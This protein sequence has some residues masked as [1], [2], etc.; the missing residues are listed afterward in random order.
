MLEHAAVAK[1]TEVHVTPFDW[2][3]QWYPVALQRD[4]DPSVPTKITLLGRDLVLWKEGVNKGE[5]FDST[6]WRCF[7]DKCPHRLAPLSEGR[8][9]SKTGHLQCAYHGWEFDRTGACTKIPQ[10]MN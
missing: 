7:M 5:M 10:V 8:I 1:A 2:L 6:S 9:D 4:L 3:R